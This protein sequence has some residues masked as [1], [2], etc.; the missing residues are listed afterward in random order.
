[1]LKPLYYLALPVGG[2]QIKKTYEG[3]S[4]FDDDLPISGSYTESGKLRFPVEDTIPNRIQAALFGQ[5]ASK[6]ARY[7]FDN[8]IAP[9]GAEQIQEY[10]DVDIPIRDYWKYRD[11][12]SGLKTA[13]EK[14]D[15]INSMNLSTEQKNILINNQLDRK[16]PVDMTDYDDYGSLEE[17]DF[18]NKNPEKYEFFESIGVS[19]QDY[20][21]ADEKTKDVYNWAYQYPEKYTVSKAVTGDVLEYK[22]YTGDLSDIRADKDA[23]GKAINGS[24]KQKK[25]DY[26]NSLNIAY[27]AKLILYRDLY[28]SDNTY[29]KQIIEYLNGRSD[30][31][32]QEKLTI[33]REL[34]FT[35]KSDGTISWN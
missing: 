14:A 29:N 25:I 35:V 19:Y 8:D 34:G 3:L 26:I 10:Q 4:M 32:F 33:M 16:E 18:A 5:Y 23:N 31:S 11:G 13:Q 24:A 9:L 15:Y 27:G 2:G 12:L 22:K 20:K 21:N 28:P 17:F 1:M 7:Y 30:I 6:D